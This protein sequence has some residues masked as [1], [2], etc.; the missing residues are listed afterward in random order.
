MILLDRNDPHKDECCIANVHLYNKTI[1]YERHCKSKSKNEMLKLSNLQYFEVYRAEPRTYEWIDFILQECDAKSAFH[2]Q[3]KNRS[4]IHSKLLANKFQPDDLS[5]AG[6]RG[7][8]FRSWRLSKYF[9]KKEKKTFFVLYSLHKND[10]PHR[11][12]TIW[13]Q[14]HMCTGRLCW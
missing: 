3:F 7:A 6:K 8:A 4:E 9:V 10:R 13:Y 2:I 1:N 11:I 12:S 14:C 5:Q